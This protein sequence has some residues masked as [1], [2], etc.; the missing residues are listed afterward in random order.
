MY[1]CEQYAGLV[2]VKAKKGYRLPWNLSYRQLGTAI[3]VLVNKPRS[4]GET[5]STLN[6]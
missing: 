1:V 3:Q 4:S 2:P 6:F 5:E